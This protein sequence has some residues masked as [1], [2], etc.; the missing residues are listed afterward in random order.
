M[1]KND[2]RPEVR[3]RL[4][5]TG[6]RIF[7]TRG[8]EGATV[9]EI[10]EQAE[11]NI[12]AINYYFG[13]KKGFYEAVR[14]YARGL[15]RESLDKTWEQAQKD[16]WRALRMRV[17]SLLDATY[18]GVMFYVSWLFLRELIN[19]DDIQPQ[20]PGSEGEIRRKVYE[21]RMT[22]LLTD[23][24][25]EAATQRNIR[26]L[27][28]TFYSM[29]QF[30]PI[31]T[32]VENKFLHGRGIFSVSTSVDRDYLTDFIMGTVRRTVEDMQA[33]SR[34]EREQLSEKARGEQSGG[35]A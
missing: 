30:L 7:A 10:S 5:S 12:A 25:G 9:R 23:L 8:F 29:C 16:P 2:D 19:T 27:R 18:D 28:Y 24:L 17:E 26:L 22:K 33:E 6:L 4:L 13:D 14:E 32:A 11:S 31:Q 15:R 3:A 35:N 20:E 34:R 1:S 21:E